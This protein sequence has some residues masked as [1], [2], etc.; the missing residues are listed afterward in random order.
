[1]FAGADGT[2]DSNKHDGGLWRGVCLGSLSWAKYVE[3][4]TDEGTRDNAMSG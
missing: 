3:A 2:G 1:V 4:T